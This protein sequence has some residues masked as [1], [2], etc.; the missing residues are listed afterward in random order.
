M[1]QIHRNIIKFQSRCNDYIDDH[2][3]SSVR[4]LKSKVQRLED[5]A[6]VGKSAGTIEGRL[7]D[8][9]EELNIVAG[10]GGMSQGHVNSLQSEAR[11]LMQQLRRI[12]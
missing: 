2:S 6:Q 4:S 5:E 1:D 9:I 10:D 8:V 12:E 11:S 3:I 7:E